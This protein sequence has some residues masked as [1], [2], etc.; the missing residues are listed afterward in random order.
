MS[1]VPLA[2]DTVYLNGIKENNE[3]V[4]KTNPV[5]DKR[6]DLLSLQSNHP[7][8]T[9]QDATSVNGTAF[10][11]QKLVCVIDNVNDGSSVKTH[12]VQINDAAGNVINGVVGLAASSD[13]IF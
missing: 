11:A 6:V 4:K 8:L 5:Y 1:F 9:L 10:D 3:L 12:D 2:A 7:V 13:K